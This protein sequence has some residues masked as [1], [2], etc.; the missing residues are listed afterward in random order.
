MARKWLRGCLVVALLAMSGVGAAGQDIPLIE[1]VKDGDAEAV[2][3]LLD[4]GGD[5]NVSEVD[6]TT[7]LHWAVHR[8]HVD[9]TD[10]L[11]RAGAN[12]RAKNRY[13]VAPLSLACLNGSEAMV[14]KLLQ[15]GADPETSSAGWRD[16]PHDSRAHRER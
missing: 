16:R 11:I 1:A 14:A 8:D 5:V 13:G 6:G 12:V 15:A 10:L 2:R 3:A 4:K 9:V 7:V